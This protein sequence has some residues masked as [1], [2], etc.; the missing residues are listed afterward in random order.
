MMLKDDTDSTQSHSGNITYIPLI[1]H[2]F[3]VILM[4]NKIE[5]VV[6]ICGTC[7]NND[8]NRYSKLS[9]FF[10]VYKTYLN[11][12]KTRRLQQMMQ[13]CKNLTICNNL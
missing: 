12:E 8:P 11:V 5:K 10:V 9:F 7:Q 6:L 3:Y 4:N 2:Y 1:R 13:F